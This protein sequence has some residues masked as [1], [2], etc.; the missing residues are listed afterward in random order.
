[1]RVGCLGGVAGI[2]YRVAG[3]GLGGAANQIDI[4]CLDS[5]EMEYSRGLLN[6][7]QVTVPI[8]FIARSEA[9]QAL[10]DLRES[11][12]TVSWMMVLSDQ[13]S[14]PTSVDSDDRL[15]SP[16]DTTAEFL[17][18]VADFTFD[19]PMNDI[20]RGS[21]TLQRSGAVVW[22]LPTADLA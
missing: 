15:V 17:A 18:Y 6:P 16:G 19:A 1:L 2:G 10:L 21:L 11:G 13:A 3:G 20:V 9:H 8:N 14:A 4:T 12:D 7:G 5:T 22:D